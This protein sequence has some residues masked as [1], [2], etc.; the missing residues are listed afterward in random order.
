MATLKI[1]K[2]RLGNEVYIVTAGADWDPAAYGLSGVLRNLGV[3]GYR[4]TGALYR[5]CDT[6]VVAMMTRHPSYL[7]MEMMACGCAVVTNRNLATGWLLKDGENCLLA[8]PSPTST[9]ETIEE[10]LRNSKLRDRLTTT[11]AQLVESK[12]SNWSAQGRRS[13]IL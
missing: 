4:A 2:Q 6:G 12:Y 5:A 8:E 1:V 3:L 7:P 11:A 9:A 10:V 13:S